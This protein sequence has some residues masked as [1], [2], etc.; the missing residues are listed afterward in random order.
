MTKK[1]LWQV[2]RT[3]STRCKQKEACRQHGRDGDAGVRSRK[4]GG[5]PTIVRL[6]GVV[7]FRR[8]SP[9]PAY[10]RP[11][12]TTQPALVW[13][14]D[15]SQDAQKLDNSPCRIKIGK[16]LLRDGGAVGSEVA[17]SDCVAAPLTRRPLPHRNTT[18][19]VSTM[20][21]QLLKAAQY[22][23]YPLRLQLLS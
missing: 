5:A 2:R 11:P 8:P 22:R 14:S 16:V 20:P 23:Q 9:S 15:Y 17:G 13:T 21:G 3:C 10:L 19:S 7:A 18:A 6:S 4:A 12:T 1:K